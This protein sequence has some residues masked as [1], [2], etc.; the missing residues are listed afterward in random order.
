[1]FEEVIV[2]GRGLTIKIIEKKISS[3]VKCRFNPLSMSRGFMGV[4]YVR[5]EGGNSCMRWSHQ[6]KI[7]VI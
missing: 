5:I 6:L 2:I 1:M 4:G 3:N 7:L